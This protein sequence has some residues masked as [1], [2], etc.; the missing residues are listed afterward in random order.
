MDLTTPARSRIAPSPTGDPHVG[1]AYMAL[2]NRA[3][4][5]KTGGKFIFRLDD[6]DRS[7]RNEKSE[8]MIYDVL[9]WLGI[10]RDE[11]PDVG[12]PH[13]PYRQSE[14]LSIYWTYVNKMLENGTA[15]R[16]FAT[17]DELEVMRKVQQAAGRPPMYDRRWREKSA[18][19]VKAKLDAG[20]DWVVRVKMPTEGEVRFTDLLRGEVVFPAAELDDKVIWKSDGFPTYH[21]ANV[22][23][24]HEFRITHILRGEEWLSSVPTHIVLMKALGFTPPVF[25]HMPLLRNADKSKVS[26]RKNPT[27]LNWFRDSGFTPEGMLN[28]LG[29]MGFSLPNDQEIFT[30]DEFVQHF[31]PSRITIGGPVF[32]LKKLEWCNGEQI[33]RLAPAGLASRLTAHLKH[34]AGRAAD[35][36]KPPEGDEVYQQGTYADVFRLKACERNTVVADHAAKWLA[37]PDLIAALAPLLSSRLHTLS[38][39]ADYLPPFFE[40]LPALP[41]GDFA[42]IKKFTPAEQLAAVEAAIAVVEAADFA[43]GA[44]AVAAMEAALRA[45][46]E[47][48]GWKVGPAFMAVRLAALRSK[49]SPPLFESMLVLGKAV[50]LKRLHD[51]ASALKARA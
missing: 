26:K 29:M 37:R 39:A 44:A 51:A 2:F 3:L 38:E 34:L 30:Y 13:A 4:A 1:T 40:E 17:G 22:V 47:A 49:I 8:Q 24:D 32:D 21:L 35:F 9:N 43:S 11:G 27:S 23:D 10:R 28:F 31:D 15:Y 48:K 20:A 46:V 50:T 14:R 6:T 25:I 5:D 33:R 45:A 16:C 7:R 19:E 42:E 41:L 36:V 18:A 12:G